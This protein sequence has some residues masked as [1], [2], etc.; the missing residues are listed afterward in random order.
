[1]N[2]SLFLCDA[3]CIDSVAT[4][5]TIGSRA[6][7]IINIVTTFLKKDNESIYIFPFLKRNICNKSNSFIP[8]FLSIRFYTQRCTKELS[9]SAIAAAGAVC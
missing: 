8:V 2:L 4:V 7:I 5:N 9:N 6:N 3:V 1:M